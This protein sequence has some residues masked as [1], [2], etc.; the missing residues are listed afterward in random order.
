VNDPNTYLGPGTGYRVSEERR[1]ELNSIRD[2]LDQ[3]EVLRQEALHEKE[4]AKRIQYRVIGS[5]G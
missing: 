1:L 3:K 2:V 4:E 5:A